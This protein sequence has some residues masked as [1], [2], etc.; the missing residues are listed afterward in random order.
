MTRP[1]GGV[2]RAVG[3]LIAAVSL[4]DAAFIAGV[5]AMGPALI[6]VAGFFATL[7]LQRYI[8]GT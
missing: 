4:V 6:A 1:A 5:G 2:P 8:S 7:G 3:L